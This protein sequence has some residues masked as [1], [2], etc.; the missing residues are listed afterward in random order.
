MFGAFAVIDG[1][2]QADW[3]VVAFAVVAVFVVR[4]VAVLL[5]LW[6]SD[7]PTS[8][9]LF[10]GWFG[11]RGIGTAVLGLVVVERGAIENI[12]RIGMVVVVAVTLS[13][14][15]HSLT[16][17]FGI[18]RLARARPD[19]RINLPAPPAPLGRACP[20]GSSRG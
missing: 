4:V 7:L 16:A 14:V 1:W 9:R 8:D 18:S 2:K 17:G 20:P 10:I 6:G 3:R 5:A 13:L 12:G 19:G 15:L 11:P